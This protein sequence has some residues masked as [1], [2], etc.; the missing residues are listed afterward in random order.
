[1]QVLLGGAGN[2]VTAGDHSSSMTWKIGV[3]GTEYIQQFLG[4]STRVKCLSSFFFFLKSTEKK[5]EKLSPGDWQSTHCSPCL[6]R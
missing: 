3:G 5:K 2:V 6:H 1:M 4:V